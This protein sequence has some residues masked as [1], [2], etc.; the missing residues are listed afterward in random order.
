M[1]EFFGSVLSAIEWCSFL[2]SPAEYEMRVFC[3]GAHGVDVGREKNEGVVGFDLKESCAWK[4]MEVLPPRLFLELGRQ[5]IF[6][7]SLR[8]EDFAT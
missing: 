5:G 8:L 3:Y 7:S 6:V 1:L 2:G 4:S